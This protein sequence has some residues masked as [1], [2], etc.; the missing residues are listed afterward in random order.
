MRYETCTIKTVTLNCFLIIRFGIAIL[1]SDGII[2]EVTSSWSLAHIKIR[3]LTFWF[4]FWPKLMFVISY[5]LWRVVKLAGTNF[6]NCIPSLKHTKITCRYALLQEMLMTW[7]V[8]RAGLNLACTNLYRR[9]YISHFF[10]VCFCFPFH[11]YIFGLLHNQIYDSTAK[12]LQCR[13]H[14]FDFQDKERPMHCYYF[15]GLKQN[16]GISPDKKE[17][18][19]IRCTVDEF[20]HNVLMY[21][22]WKPGMEVYVSHVKKKNLPKFVY[23]GVLSFPTV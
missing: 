8:G 1:P 13:L 17:T 16:Q 9:L 20:R 10:S 12:K 3:G 18:F 4:I 6:L 19:D 7:D 22:M 15:M 11:S 23:H 5:R 21:T 2:I 14:P